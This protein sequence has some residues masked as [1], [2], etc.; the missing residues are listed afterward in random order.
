LFDFVQVC[1]ETICIDDLR[2]VHLRRVSNYALQST[3]EFVKLKR[4]KDSNI[5][6]L[7]T[8]EINSDPNKKSSLSEDEKFY[9][10][11]PVCTSRHAPFNRILLTFDSEHVQQ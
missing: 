3:I 11:L 9:Q 6:Q 10:G 5:I 2:T 4:F 7:V 1:Q 8:D